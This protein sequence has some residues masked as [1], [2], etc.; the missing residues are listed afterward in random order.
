[1]GRKWT[2]RSLLNCRR[3]ATRCGA[4]RWW[5]LTG[6]R[7]RAARCAAGTAPRRERAASR[8]FA[9]R[10]SGLWKSGVSQY[11]LSQT[12]HDYLCI[13]LLVMVAWVSYY[14]IDMRKRL[15]CINLSL[16]QET[17]VITQPTYP[18]LT[19]ICTMFFLLIN[20]NWTEIEVREDEIGDA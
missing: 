8:G 13:W 5:T 6:G 18:Q 2:H 19:D 17:A 20:A 11:Q 14:P 1:M 12:M 15:R 16:W 9:G 4:W 3:S 10:D 7:W